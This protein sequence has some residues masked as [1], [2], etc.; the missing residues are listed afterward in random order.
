MTIP[1]YLMESEDEIKRL[2]LKTRRALI[3]EQALWAGL[4]PGH[5]V[6]DIGCGP[7]KTTAVL[8]EIVQPDGIAVGIDA[9]PDRIEHACR[10]YGRP[11][12]DFLQ[13]DFLQPMDDVEPFDFIWVR[14][15]LEYYCADGPQLA[16]KLARLLKPGG[17][18]CL[19]DIDLSCMCHYGLPDRM[20]R[21]IEMIMD[22]MLKEKNFDPYAGR[23]LYS[24][25]YDLGFDDIDVDLR[26]DHIIY[27]K[28]SDV[29]AFN[30][31]RKIETGSKYL[32]PRLEEFYPGGSDEVMAE[33]DRA[34]ADPRRFIYAPLI[35]C[36][37]RKPAAP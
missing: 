28:L 22:T 14:F 29:D 30:F 27:G 1:E 12:L 15:V 23:K 26:A 20:A 36:R 21:A 11:G 3:R 5:R 2:E 34:I 17:I 13:R 24:F 18:L 33:F 10:S 25:L 16:E 19:I 31:R 37:G 6:A 9:S 35:T 32:G 8:H 7:G 4:Q